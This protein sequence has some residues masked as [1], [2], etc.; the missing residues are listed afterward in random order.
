MIY[1]A[2]LSTGIVP[3]SIPSDSSKSVNYVDPLSPAVWP[4]RMP[5]F[6]DTVIGPEGVIGPQLI[7]ELFMRL[8]YMLRK[9][10]PLSSLGL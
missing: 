8:T 10:G 2:F 9:M 6:L 1:P 3:S 7:P 5:T 4:I